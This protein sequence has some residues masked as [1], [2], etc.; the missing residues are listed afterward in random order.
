MFGDIA[1]FLIDIVFTLFGAALILR[2]WMQ[3]VRLPPRNPFSQGVFQ[4]T[5]WLV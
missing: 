5:D 2:V 4:I 1:R 3:A